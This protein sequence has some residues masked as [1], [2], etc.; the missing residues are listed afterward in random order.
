ME[1]HYFGIDRLALWRDES[2]RTDRVR[3]ESTGVVKLFRDVTDQRNWRY[4]GYRADLYLTYSYVS[5]DRPELG[6]GTTFFMK[7]GDSYIGFW[8]GRDITYNTI[9]A[10]PYVLLPTQISEEE[11]GQKFPFLGKVMEIRFDGSLFF[12]EDS[13]VEKEGEG[14]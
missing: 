4:E 14:Q 3:A 2:G 9:I 12:E 10:A 1:R 11:A 13:N 5:D 6:I 8:I 7:K